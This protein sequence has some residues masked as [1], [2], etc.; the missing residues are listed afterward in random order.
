MKAKSTNKFLSVALALFMLLMSVPFSMF[1][2][3]ARAEEDSNTHVFESKY[4]AEKAQGDYEDGES[5][6][7]AQDDYFTLYM[8]KKTKIDTSSGGYWSDYNS[9]KQKIARVNFGDKGDVTT[10]KNVISFKTSSA[11]KVKVWYVQ[12]ADCNAEKPARQMAIWDGKGNQVAITSI[13]DC[14]KNDPLV[15]TLEIK[16][17]NTYYLGGDIGNNYIFKIEVQEEAVA[18]KE[19]VLDTTTDLAALS[20]SDNNAGTSVQAGTDKFFTVLYGAKA[21]VDGSN[22]E[23]DDG[24]KGTQRLNFGASA[25]TSE[26]AIKFVTGSAATVKVWWAYNGGSEDVPDSSRQMVVLDKDGKQVA[27]TK[28]SHLKNKAYIDTFTLENEGTYYLGSSG[29]GLYIFKVQV[30]AGASK[31]ER[32]D[33]SKVEA[34]VITDA[35]DDGEGNIVVKVTA[36]VSNEGGDAVV[37]TMT[38]ANGE[39][40]T[41][42]SLAESKEHEL[43]FAPS[44]SGEYTFKAALTRA[45]EEDKTSDEV[46]A[47][48]K[49][50]LGK[51]IISSATSKGNGSIEVVWGEVKEATKYEVFV[52]GASK[53]TTEKTTYMI[54][55]LEVGKKYNIT[56]KAI[57]NDETGEASEAIT[58]EATKEA[59]ITWSH[60]FFGPSTGESKCTAKAND[61]GS[62]TVTSTGGKIVYNS[63]D[64]ISYYYTAVPTDLNFKF[65]AKVHV[66]S[67]KDDGGQQGFGI[68]A[69]DSVP[70]V[71]GT[72]PNVSNQYMV[73]VCKMEYWWDKE[74]QEVDHNHLATNPK[75]SYRVGVGV[76]AKVGVTL[77]SE[78][79][80]DI[81]NRSA[82]QYPLDL[83]AAKNDREAGTYNV[84]DLD[85]CENKDSVSGTTLGNDGK[86]ISDFY[87]E[88][89]RN[90]TG[91]FCT[92]YADDG[93]TIIGQQKF[94]DRDALSVIDKD[95]VYVGMFAARAAKATFSNIELTTIAPEDDAPAEERPVEKIQPVVTV[96]SSSKVANS[97]KYKLL[98]KSNIAGTV[99]VKLADKTVATDLKLTGE[100]KYTEQE[101]TIAAGTNKIE[102]I[103]TPDKDQELPEYTELSSTDPVTTTLNVKYETYFANQKNLY[104]SPKGTKGGNGGKEYPL[105]IYTAV[106]VA[107]PGQ[108]IIL[109]EG[110]YELTSQVLIDRGMDGTAENPINMIADP[111]AKTRPVLDFKGTKSGLKTGANYWYFQGFDVTNAG[112]KTPGFIV[113]GNNNTVDNVNAYNNTDTGIYIKAFKDSNDPK[114]YWPKNNLI[115]NCTSHNNADPSYADADGFACKLTSGE[116]NVFDGCIAY[117]NADDGWD[118]YA[119]TA[120]G[121]IG[122]VTIKNCVAYKN[123]YLEDGTDAGNGNGFKLGGENLPGKHKIINSIAFENKADGIT[124]NS[125][126][127]III[128]NCTSFNNGDTNVTVYTN[129]KGADTDFSI[130]GIISFRTD[131]VKNVED[132]LKPD[133]KQKVE[134]LYAD[135]NY[136]WFGGTSANKSAAKVTAD[137]FESLEFK[138]SIA[139]NADNTINME[140]F[141][142]LKDTAPEDAGARISGTPSKVFTINA[143][144]I[145]ETGNLTVSNTVTGAGDKDKEYKF[146][147]KLSDDR[148]NGTYGEMTF[149]DGVATF[150]LKDGKSITA[151]GLPVDVTYTVT[152]DDYSS[153]GYTT[154]ATGATGTITKDE[155]AKAEF[156]N[157]KP[158]TGNL[159]VSNT[160]TSEGDEDKAFTFTITLS[161]T[162]VNGTFGD[163]TFTDGVATFTLKNGESKTATGLPANVSYEIVESDN[164]G[165]TV[166]ATNDKGEIKVDETVNA[167]FSNEKVKA[168]DTGYTTH[169]PACF[170]VMAASAVVIKIGLDK[171][172]RKTK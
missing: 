67:W 84:L 103:F 58:V 66:D 109:M 9:D 134:D 59:Q 27:G 38:D 118:L 30:V 83:Y 119:K 15:A 123:G 160:V 41:K 146:T 152:E 80:P 116:G 97:D 7:Y 164:D 69:L 154:T 16:E 102:V 156:T 48:F 18:P 1:A 140:G 150:T 145:P 147:V 124:S 60:K 163:I 19:Y 77:N 115:L 36:D 61:D 14:K 4:L 34:P 11:A 39:T 98:I 68:L 136:Y 96:G 95:N 92:Y 137:M 44:S 40:T 120:T 37:V 155:T 157:H 85:S 131:A 153:E 22:K 117:N 138:G 51:P 63:D 79:K 132:S 170:A 54:T 71:S 82:V 6:A 35:K 133:G 143:D 142:V 43:K 74:N 149:T 70:A 171:K 47:N 8:S 141:L 122:A 23:F 31:V 50:P 56:V 57:R 139:R 3:T 25:T 112:E 165:Y 87:F 105:D 86:G 17:A 127:D 29:G 148:I 144:P 52:D 101:I 126:P 107:K 13:T 75:Y 81:S 21:K 94:Y 32:G 53:D 20:Q 113:G 42:Q 162:S 64:G 129:V 159:T 168:P 128:E 10:P 49:L 100:D 167:D 91:Y 161:D 65:R 114:D 12:G 28:D 106:N 46:K 73:A 108:T 5:V 172:R 24:Y 26:Y 110:T 55:G 104:V 72:E 2:T 135:N 62:V 130:S 169:I 99:E 158:E 76:N 111:E 33:W 89:Q 93:K 90:N 151:E 125:C 166:T 121:S 78:G 88:I 45:E